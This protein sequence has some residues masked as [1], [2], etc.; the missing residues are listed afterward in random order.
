MI[1]IERTKQK[2][3]IFNNKNEEGLTRLYMKTDIIL[4]ADVFEKFIK[5]SNE[6]YG[7]IP[8]YCVS[9]CSYSLQGQNLQIINYKHYKIRIWFC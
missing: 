4:L 7:S 6:D 1:M 3:K 2:I 5:V 8:F 9:T